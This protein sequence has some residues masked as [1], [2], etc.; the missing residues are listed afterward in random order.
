MSHCCPEYKLIPDFLSNPLIL[1][2]E[3]FWDS[4]LILWLPEGLLWAE[5][6][7][8]WHSEEFNTEDGMALQKQLEI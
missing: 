7:C 2:S 5:H 8:G 1:S 4:T 3:N 6:E